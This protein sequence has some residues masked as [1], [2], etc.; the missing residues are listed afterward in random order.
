MYY[1]F[2]IKNMYFKDNSEYLYHILK[3]L[4]YMH[5]EN[6]NYGVSLYYSICSLFDTVSLKRYVRLKYK[7][8]G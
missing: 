2:I 8:Q 4:K 7:L 5:K 3:K 6:Y 1:L